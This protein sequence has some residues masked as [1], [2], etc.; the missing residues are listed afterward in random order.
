M[1]KGSALRPAQIT[2]EEFDS[3][4]DKIF[5]KKKQSERGCNSHLVHTDELAVQSECK[6]CGNCTKD[7]QVV[8][9]AHLPV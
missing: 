6:N 4:W 9:I 3:N 7:K 5:G 8:Y 1:S 2:K